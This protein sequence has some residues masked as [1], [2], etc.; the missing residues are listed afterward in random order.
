[1]ASAS[2]EL[3]SGGLTRRTLAG[4]P[5]TEFPIKQFWAKND[6][7]DLWWDLDYLY[8]HFRD[9]SATKLP[10]NKWLGDVKA[11]L[12]SAPATSGSC[13]VHLHRA[14]QPANLLNANTCTTVGVLVILAKCID[15]SRLPPGVDV[16]TSV[17]RHIVPASCSVLQPLAPRVFNCL[18]GEFSIDC[19]GRMYGWQL[20]CTA[21]CGHKRVADA[22]ERLWG[23][24]HAQGIV[25]HPFQ[26]ES[27]SFA[28]VV[29]F[30]CLIC[31]QR[32][33]EGRNLGERLTKFRTECLSIVVSQCLGVLFS[34]LVQSRYCNDGNAD[35]LRP[36]PAIRTP[37]CKRNYVYVDAEAAWNLLEKARQTGTSLQAALVMKNDEAAYGCGVGQGPRWI[38]IAL[39]LYYDRCKKL[40]QKDDINHYNFVSDP[41]HHSYRECLVTLA[42]SWAQDRAS[43]RM[44]MVRRRRREESGEDEEM[45][46]MTGRRR[47]R[48]SE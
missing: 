13:H 27:H 37:K 1:M 6:T 42:Y 29:I 22:V 40:W 25:R 5:L 7:G 8:A 41:G 30:I 14:T 4:E 10:R 11:A 17:F 38:N 48:R 31:K 45:G 47:R 16:P 12:S 9:T 44:R 15:A 26:C 19:D 32:K 46:K 24:L 3:Q 28:D 33:S 43:M 23:S 34:E 35:V 18:Y 39:Q 36:P 2:R 21:V 20:L